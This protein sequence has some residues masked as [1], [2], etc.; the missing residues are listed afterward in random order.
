MKL[1]IKGARENNLKGIDLTIDEESLLCITGI[2]GSGKSSLV[3]STINNEAKRRMAEIYGKSFQQ[4][5]PTKV[6]EIIGLRPVLAVEQNTINR[7]P[8]SSLASASGIYPFL[9]I[10]FVNFG[11]RECPTCGNEIRILSKDEIIKQIETLKISGDIAIEVPLINNSF[12]S[13]KT[14]LSYLAEEFSSKQ[15]LVDNEAYDKNQLLNP[16]N[17]HY[18]SVLFDTI[19]KEVKQQEIRLCVESALG[20]GGSTLILRYHDKSEKLSVSNICSGCNKILTEIKPKHFYLSCSQCQGSGCVSCR[21]SGLLPEVASITWNNRNIREIIGLSVQEMNELIQG[22]FI[23]INAERLIS[24]IKKRLLSLIS[25]GLGYLS[26]DRASPSLSRGEGQRVQLAVAL[27]NK[28][29]DLLYLMDEPTIGLSNFDLMKIKPIFRHLKGMKVMVEHDKMMIASAD[30]VI[31]LGPKAGVHGGEIIFDGVPSELWS[32]KTITGLTLSKE[33]QNKMQ[34]KEKLYH[35]YLTIEGITFRSFHDVNIKIPLQRFVVITGPSG[36][37]KSSL[38]EDIIYK[39]LSTR[40]PHGCRS[41][42]PQMN[43]ILVDQSPIGK[44]P[45]SNPATYTKLSDKIRDIFAQKTSLTASHY[46]FNRPEGACPECS[47]LGSIEYKMRYLPS[48]WIKCDSC[49]GHRFSDEVLQEKITLGE[50]AYNIADLYSMSIEE[51]FTVIQQ[52]NLSK[53]LKIDTIHVLQSLIDVGLGYLTLGQESPSLSGGEAQRVKLAKYLSLKKLEEKILLLDEPSTGLSTYD[54]NHLLTIINTLVQKGASVIVVEHNSNFIKASDWIIDLGPGAGAEGGKIVFSGKYEDFMKNKNSATVI[55]LIEEQLVEPKGKIE[56]ANESIKEL[57]IH[58]AYANNLKNITVKLP[59]NKINIITGISGSGKSSLINDILNAEAQRRYLETLSMY[60]RQS[61][62]EGPYALVD[63]IQGL[64]V[65]IHVDPSKIGRSYNYRST[66]GTMTEI[67]H[68]LAVLFSFLGENQCERCQEVMTR[69]KGVWECKKCNIILEIPSPRYFSPTNYASS[70]TRCQGI[71][72]IQVPDPQK[73]IIN[74]EKPL[75]SGAMYSPGFFP[76]GFLCKPYNSGYYIIQAVGKKFGFNPHETPWNEMSEEAKQAFLFGIADPLTVTFENRK[77][78]Q[79][80]RN[81]LYKGFYSF[82]GDW[83]IGGTYSVFE[84]CPQCQGER[85]RLEYLKIKVQEKSINELLEKP[86]SILYHILKELEK[87][88]LEYP[89][90][91]SLEIIMKRIKFLITVGL[92]YINCSRVVMTLSAGEAQRIKLASILGGSLSGV[93]VI[94]DEP[95]RGLHPIEIAAL[96]NA[97]SEIRDQENTVII[98]EHDLDIIRHGDYILELGPGSGRD[99][100]NIIYQGLF[101]GYKNSIISKW[102]SAEASLAKYHVRRKPKKWLEIHGARENNLKTELIRIPMGAIVVGICGLSGSGKSTLIIDTLGRALAPKK[103]TTSVAYEPISPGKHDKIINS[104]T[105]TIIIDQSRKEVS[106]PLNFFGLLKP[107]IKEFA[108]SLQAKSLGLSEQQLSKRCDVCKGDGI[109]RIGMGFLPDV[110]YECDVCQ[111]TGLSEILEINCHG[112]TIKECFDMSLDQIITIFP[113]LKKY[114]SAA[115]ELGLGYLHVNQPRHSLSGGECQR[116]KIAKELVK[117]SSVLDMLLILDEPSIGQ[118]M[119]EITLLMELFS[120]LIRRGHTILVVEH[121]PHIL[122]ACDWLIEL[123]PEGGPN[124]GYIIA[125]GTPE[126]V[127]ESN[128][129]TAPYL[130]KVLEKKQ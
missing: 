54:I 2:S 84:P 19:S 108:R 89:A 79:Y 73:L 40:K 95:S 44:N 20:M 22:S 68:H 46:S 16:D 116:L 50:K 24:E 25:M 34:L 97:L 39:S 98:V 103:I 76:K 1:S 43:C 83:D 119:E 82:I 94:I 61:I 77:G 5:T 109:I 35:N 26:L 111:G 67:A 75:C 6:D 51:V 41:I 48:F 58:N 49:G 27:S 52:T 18:I 86:F 129:P 57:Q 105:K 92:G 121:H 85:F 113:Q 65:V 28:L 13:H 38:V 101:S 120:R 30:R 80:T 106:S 91:Y 72:T 3:F 62:R 110:F 53:K 122:A 71:G 9:K 104:P 112:V 81:L 64:G 117:K 126:E 88:E 115:I 107:L 127:S 63:E 36:S 12:G 90:K 70:C 56:P 14:I 15:I 4:S 118:S 93:T 23:P 17:P 33:T 128:T 87:Q 31:D 60:E 11:E 66:V 102:V 21:N 45:R 10:F 42:T 125:E 78:V 8:L 74:P 32:A 59:K 114:L 7:N 130:R 47:G 69:K 100:G 124:G 37:G 96:N 123:G 99:G 55:G 29:E